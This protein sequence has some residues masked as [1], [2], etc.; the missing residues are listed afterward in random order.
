MTTNN[1]DTCYVTEVVKGHQTHYLLHGPSAQRLLA[2]VTDGLRGWLD[3]GLSV[4]VADGLYVRTAVPD[5]T[6]WVCRPLQE[7][8]HA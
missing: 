7:Q 4:R 5:K 6:T 1:P 8:A 2:Q 3:L